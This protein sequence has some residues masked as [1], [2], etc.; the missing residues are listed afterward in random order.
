M[1]ASQLDLN[2]QVER[3]IRLHLKCQVKQE[4]FGHAYAS[5]V[6]VSLTTDSSRSE[7]P[8]RLSSLESLEGSFGHVNA[9]KR[10]HGRVHERNPAMV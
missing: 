1:V 7:E 4:V 8:R 6:T 2:V 5:S 3:K 9:R 10:S